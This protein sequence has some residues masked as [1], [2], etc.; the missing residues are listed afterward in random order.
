M[1]QVHTILPI[2]RMNDLVYFLAMIFHDIP[3]AKKTEYCAVASMETW[4]LIVDE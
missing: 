2:T 3:Q 4:R 1:M